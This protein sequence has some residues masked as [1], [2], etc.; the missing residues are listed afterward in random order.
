MI[1]QN[2][3]DV[4][5]TWFFVNILQIILSA[6]AVVIGVIIYTLIKKQLNKMTEKNKL[7]VS[8]A[9]TIRRILKIIIGLIIISAI[10]YQFIESLGVITSL[11]TLMGSTIIGFASVNTLGNI[12][13]GFIILGSR[14][15]NVDD[16]ILFNDRISKVEEIK[17]IFTQ[18][19]DL[20]GVKIS[21]PNQKFLSE[22]T[23]DLG[24]KSVI[25]R[26]IIIT[27]DY[28]EDRLKVET[29]LLEAA[30]AVPSILED[31][32]PFVW[33]SGFLNF[34][35]EYKLF[36]FIRNIA[37]VRMIEADLRASILDTARKYKIEISTPTMIKNV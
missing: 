29:A 18:L 32:K 35:V 13:S 5:V 25:R 6:A 20:D 31:P 7:D 9:K 26:N 27:A 14:P 22:E 30:K 17:L 37:K 12:I 16:Y 19:V 24:K 11:F 36:V 3:L 10:L 21:V 15:F 2:F 28:G 33:I 34:A 8:T 23:E 4:I 1:F